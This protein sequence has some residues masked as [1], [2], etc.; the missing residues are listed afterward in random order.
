[1][2]NFKSILEDLEIELEGV[3]EDNSPIFLM[4]KYIKKELENKG[5]YFLDNIDNALND[6]D[7]FIIKEDNEVGS[8]INNLLDYLIDY[9]KRE[10]K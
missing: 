4:I 5:N 1:M 7:Y 10:N 6:I 9:I 8:I 3:I 2:N